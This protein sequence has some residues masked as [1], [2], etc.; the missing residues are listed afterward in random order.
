MFLRKPSRGLVLTSIGETLALEARGLL[1]HADEFELIAGAMG[2]AFE[3]ELSVACFVNLAPFVFTRLVAEFEAQYPSI[4]VHMV[5]G[6]HEEV[7]QS[8][9]SGVAELALTFDLALVDKFRVAPLATLP[10]RVLLSQ[11]HSLAERPYVHLADL[12][13]EPYIL[14]DLPHTREYF[15]S[16]FYSLHIDPLVRF[17][18]TSF[19]AVR[20]MVG[21]GLGYSL[22]N[23]TPRVQETYDGGQVVHVSLADDLRPLRIVLVS[24]KRVT[25]RRVTRT[26]ADYTRSFFKSWRE[27]NSINI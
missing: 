1:A 4:K 21:N 12:A 26:F 27:E 6:D 18:S 14:M 24:L 2:N 8:L 19:E 3:G 7:L 20:T 13:G 17:R 5:I 25:Q 22:L 9:R 11:R 10:P 16:L 15:L 23:I